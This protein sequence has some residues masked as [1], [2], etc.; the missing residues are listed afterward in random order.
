MDPSASADVATLLHGTNLE[1][2][3]GT[4]R[5]Y[6]YRI[7]EQASADRQNPRLLVVLSTSPDLDGRRACSGGDAVVSDGVGGAPD[8]P[9]ATS[10]FRRMRESRRRAAEATRLRVGRSS[11]SESL[12]DRRKGASGNQPVF[13]NAIVRAARRDRFRSAA[14]GDTHEAM[15]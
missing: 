11:S 2:G 8:D 5:R 9:R 7:Q 12:A 6:R 15:R 14:L 10:A 1:R 13:A 3:D 4:D